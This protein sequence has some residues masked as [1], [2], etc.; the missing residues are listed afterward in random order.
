MG[1]AGVRIV[2]TIAVALLLGSAA[3][4]AD[5]LSDIRSLRSLSAEAAQ[6]IRLQAQ[7]RVTDTYATE[8]KQEAREELQS[9]ADDAGTPQLKAIARQATQALDRNNSQALTD[10]AERLLAMEGPHGRAD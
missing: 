8:M 5:T 4:H 1:Q 7:H 9:S 2:A 6:V 3:A 10:I